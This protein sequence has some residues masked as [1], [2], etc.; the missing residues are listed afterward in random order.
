LNNAWK[1]LPIVIFG[2]G[3]LAKEIK[4][5]IDDINNSTHCKIFEVVGYVSHNYET[6][7]QIFEGVPVV[8]CNDNFVEYSKKFELL[9]V[10]IALGDPKSKRVID[11]NILSKCNNLV[12][13]NLIHPKANISSSTSN[14]FGT[15]AII[16]AGV[17]LTTNIKFGKFVLININA[18]IGHDAIFEDY[19]SVNPLS[20][21][22]G[23]VMIGD[24][25]LV[26]AGAS[27]REKTL[28]GKRSIVGLGAIVVKNVEDDTV[29]IC[30][31]ATKLE[32]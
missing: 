8:A 4:V 18:T 10:T 19:S 11:E 16:C 6:I 32:K 22:S 7:S 5:M 23:N 2:I 25:T 9:G 14:D 15:G 26:G 17:T 3:G 29:V 24:T 21:I 27:I 20:S 1:G 31:P 30:K 28:V 13:P 12:Y